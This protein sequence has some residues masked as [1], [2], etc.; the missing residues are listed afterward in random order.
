MPFPPEAFI[1]GAQRAGTTSL[2]A[3]LDQ[4][5][6]IVLS[7][8][9]LDVLVKNSTSTTAA[10]A[11]PGP[12]AAFGGGGGL[13][14]ATQGSRPIG[15]GAGGAGGG[16]ARFAPGGVG[17]GVTQFGSAL[18]NVRASVGFSIVLYGLLAA[19]FIAIAGSAIPAYLIAKVRPA[20]VMRSE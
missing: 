16:G 1:I 7:N 10:A 9:V 6:G 14:N 12:R 5:P 2:S 3:L 20:E 18:G 17:R 11:A 15:A 13:A 4:H 19:A 8:P